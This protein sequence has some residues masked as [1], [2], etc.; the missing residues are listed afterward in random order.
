MDRFEAL[1][2]PTRRAI[3]SM[4]AEREQAAGEIAGAFPITAPAISQHLRILREQGLVRTEKRGQ[5]RI[6]SLDPHGLAAMER[7]ISEIRAT[8]N[9]R[10][11]RLSA[12]LDD[13]E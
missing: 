4:L 13:G 1:A 7:W 6:Y 2:D 10:L 9:G 11:D 5:R 12:V 3:I 8:W